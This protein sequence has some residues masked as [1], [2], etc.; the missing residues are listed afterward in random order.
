MKNNEREKIAAIAALL[1]HINSQND[2]F[3]QGRKNNNVW[4][5]EHRRKIMGLKG[6][7]ESKRSRT[8]WR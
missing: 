2:K 6:L 8:S 1:I 7:R 3:N 5:H 4:A